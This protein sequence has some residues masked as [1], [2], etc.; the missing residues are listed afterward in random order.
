MFLYSKIGLILQNMSNVLKHVAHIKFL[1]YE[2]ENGINS[3]EELKEKE[4][5]D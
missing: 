2:P 4:S 3:K 5:N 1:M